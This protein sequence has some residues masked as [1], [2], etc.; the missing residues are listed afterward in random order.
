MTKFHSDD[1]IQFLRLVSPDN[2]NEYAKQLQRCMIHTLHPPFH[3]F[4]TRFFIDMFCNTVNVVEDCPI[5]EGM[6]NFFQ[7]SAGGSV[8]INLIHQIRIIFM[9]KMS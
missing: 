2:M 1:Y 3:F 9:I 5:F 6:F 8:G 4:T 7:I